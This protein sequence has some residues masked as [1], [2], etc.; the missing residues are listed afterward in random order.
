MI[1][2]MRILDIEED[3]KESELIDEESLSKKRKKS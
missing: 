3:T 2:K 1:W